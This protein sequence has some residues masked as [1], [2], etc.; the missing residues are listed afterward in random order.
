MTVVGPPVSSHIT[1]EKRARRTIPAGS[2]NGGSMRM[3]VVSVCSSV[4]ELGLFFGAAAALCM[5]LLA[6]R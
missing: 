4:V 5:G 2:F 3:K 6:L 1:G